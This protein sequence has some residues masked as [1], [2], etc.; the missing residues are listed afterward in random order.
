MT[1]TLS[2]TSQLYFSQDYQLIVGTAHLLS[3]LVLPDL[4]G[5]RR[6]AMMRKLTMMFGIVLALFVLLTHV[7]FA[8]T[9][10]NIPQIIQ[11]KHSILTIQ[12]LEQQGLL[13]PA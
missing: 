6:T 9:N 11:I 10:D 7:A 1:H 5:Q 2:I 8:Q 3:S 13:T 4:P 12:E